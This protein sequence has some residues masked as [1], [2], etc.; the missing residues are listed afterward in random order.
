MNLKM[1]RNMKFEY[2]QLSNA[3][4]NYISENEIL[5][6]IYNKAFEEKQ[7][8][9]GSH[10]QSG[11]NNMF[12][13]GISSR[14]G[15]GVAQQ[16]IVDKIIQSDQDLEGLK[17][18]TREQLLPSIKAVYE[19]GQLDFSSVVNLLDE[20]KL[21]DQPSLDI[22]RLCKVFQGD[23]PSDDLRRVFPFDYF[24]EGEVYN[25]EE[26][27]ERTYGMISR[28]LQDLFVSH[29]KEYVTL[30]VTFLGST[31]ESSSIMDRIYLDTLM[32]IGERYNFS[33]ETVMTMLMLF[34]TLKEN[35]PELLKNNT[36]RV[37]NSYRNNEGMK[38]LMKQEFE[39]VLK[40]ICPMEKE[41]LQLVR[42]S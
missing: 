25:V 16:E 14:Q 33:K 41:L 38:A 30:M 15:G 40:Q 27:A 10:R 37:L 12:L 32:S 31:L 7:Q 18:Y 4:I 26:Q 11:A 22:G 9:R 36:D 17:K 28:N 5:E 21:G 34:N 35:A 3:S 8:A 39:A 23:I 2:T 20:L 29:D 24:L 6:A 13:T 1:M 42:D 19:E